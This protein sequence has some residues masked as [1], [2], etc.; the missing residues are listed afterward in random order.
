MNNKKTILIYC[1]W[2]NFGGAERALVNLLRVISKKDFD[3]TLMLSNKN[4]PFLEDIPHS[5]RIITP[6]FKKE[7][8]ASF[9]IKT[10]IKNKLKQKKLFVAISLS[11]AKLLDILFGWNSILVNLLFEKQNIKY[12]YIFNWSNVSGFGHII[13][14]NLYKFQKN[15]IW[16]HSNFIFGILKNKKYKKFLNNY[17]YIFCV[18]KELTNKAQKAYKNVSDKIVTLYNPVDTDNILNLS[19]GDGFKD[20][21]NGYRI[22]SVGRLN[23]V[24]AFD[25]AIKA[26]RILVDN[27]YNIKWFIVGDGYERENLVNLIKENKL[28][29]TFI[30]LG[31]KNNPYP[32]FKECDIYVQPSRSEGYCLALAE[33]KTLNKPIVTTVFSGTYEQIKDKE[34]GI[35]VKTNPNSIATGIRTILDNNEL[36]EKLVNNLKEENKKTKL[37]FFSELN[38][39]L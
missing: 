22:L 16:I 8:D 13:S 18:S 10:L 20:N 38:K 3:I 2:S 27:G 14:N 36:K 19:N 5:V 6:P 25:I 21:Y 28:E 23:Y 9:G 7:M 35:I 26:C 29:N 4:F 24:K 15:Y 34:T 31:E 30:L 37:D 17:D 39:F 12:D 11:F 33:A 32:F 1:L